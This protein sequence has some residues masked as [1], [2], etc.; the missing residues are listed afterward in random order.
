[1]S[2]SESGSLARTV[3][4]LGIAALAVLLVQTVVFAGL[5]LLIYQAIPDLGS[6]LSDFVDSQ[7][8]AGEES[9]IFGVDEP[10]LRARKVLLYH[11][12]NSRTAKDV[13]ARLIYLSE[14]D[15]KAPID[16][17]ISTQGG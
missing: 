7:I 14:L 5:G 6:T 3:T 9:P 4:I 11:D 2:Q 8:D 10:L 1:M 15:P 17:Y 16:L 13:S 12:V